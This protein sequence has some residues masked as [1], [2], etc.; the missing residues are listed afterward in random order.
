VVDSLRS[1]STASLADA[2]RSH[3][4]TV[5]NQHATEWSTLQGASFIAAML[6]DL[7]RLVELNISRNAIGNTGAA[8]LAQALAV[9][10]NVATLNLRQNA[11]GV[12]A[13]IALGTVLAAGPPAKS[14]LRHVDLSWN[15]LVRHS[16]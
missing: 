2:Q 6:A 16:L 3:Y 12:D 10:N 14:R 4:K 8:A 15:N 1:H 11:L 13:A 7:P 5:A 9:P